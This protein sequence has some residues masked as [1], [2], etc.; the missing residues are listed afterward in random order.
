MRVL[1]VISRV[2]IRGRQQHHRRHRCCANESRSWSD[3][4]KSQGCCLPW[5]AENARKRARPIDTV[6]NPMRFLLDVWTLE[7][8]E[9]KFVL[10]YVT[11]F[12]VICYT[13]NRKHPVFQHPYIQS[14]GPYTH[15][16]IFTVVR[17]VIQP[18]ASLNHVPSLVMHR[19]WFG[20]RQHT[21]A[22]KKWLFIGFDI[23][24]L[25]K[26]DKQHFKIYKNNRPLLLSVHCLHRMHSHLPSLIYSWKIVI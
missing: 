13:R 8:T 6:F 10:F 12:V 24:F 18:L 17:G 2:F 7:L 9:Y 25:I 4:V 11:I 16:Y 1:N 20:D 22:P 15:P 26:N 23:E 5:E 19:R 21:A 3:A 14:Q